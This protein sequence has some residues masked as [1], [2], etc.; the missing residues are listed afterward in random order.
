MVLRGLYDA[1]AETLWEM[2]GQHEA[3]TVM[4]VAHN[5]GIHNL[6]STLAQRCAGAEAHRVIRE[7]P[8]AACA[9]FVIEPGKVMLEAVI[10]PADLAKGGAA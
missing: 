1:E 2:F 8:P 9:V 5:P 6:A 10:F 4:L 7:F 3:E